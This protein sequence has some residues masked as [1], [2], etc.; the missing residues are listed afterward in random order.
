MAY[1][2]SLSADIYI[3]AFFIGIF[4]WGINKNILH[5]LLVKKVVVGVLF[6]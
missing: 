6:L 3:R 1:S 2:L 4:D 5:K